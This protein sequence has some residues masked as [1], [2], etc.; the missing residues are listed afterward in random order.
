MKAIRVNQPGGRDN[1]LIENI[2]IP[3]PKS[4]EVLI[5]IIATGINFIDVYQREGI[6]PAPMPHTVGSEASGI[7]E[8]I[9]ADV[10][11]VSIGDKVAY[12]MVLGSYAE[13]AIVPKDKIVLVPET[14]DL[15]I[16]AAIMLQGLTVEYLTSDCFKIEKNMN[17]FIHAAAGGV[18]LLLTQVAKLMGAK[19]FGTTS[20][21]DKAELA[22]KAG[23]DHVIQYTKNNFLTETNKIIGESQM[24]VVYDSVGETTINDSLKLL[25]A[26]GSLIAFGQ[27]GGPAPKIEPLDLKKQGSIFFTRPSL[28]DY[29]QNISELE[30]RANRLF[31][32]ISDKKVNVRIDR[33]LELEEAQEG[34]RLLESRATAGKLILINK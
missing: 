1:L 19:V 9:G 4:N 28:V 21:E 16:A 22:Y 11:N 24:H 26:R 20:T 2:D 7:V 17:V 23:A 12:A 3:Y 5:K 8:A 32:W 34:H 10:K 33:Q 30:N 14:I 18:G 13:Y 6:Y 27:S 29:I 31:S 15:K 25:K